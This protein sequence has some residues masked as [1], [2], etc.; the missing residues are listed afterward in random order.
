MTTTNTV[1]YRYLAKCKACSLT[2]SAMGNPTRADGGSAVFV[3][4]TGNNSVACRGC[5]QPR[6][7]TAVNGKTSHKHVCG[8]KCM[9]STGPSCECSCGGQNH[10]ASHAA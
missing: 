10:G 1:L 6:R 8:A 2:T 3:D 4:K 5:G 7:A 9:A